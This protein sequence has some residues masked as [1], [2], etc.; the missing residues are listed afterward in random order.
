MQACIWASVCTT[1]HS[2]ASTLGP[3]LKR[4]G[5]TTAAPAYG[6]LCALESDR[7]DQY[8]TLSHSCQDSA[9]NKF[10]CA[11]L[12]AC[13]TPLNGI[14]EGSNNEY[15]VGHYAAVDTF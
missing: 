13:Q 4:A 15:T 12:H 5:L 3:L 10:L 11:C 7:A 14:N 2:A 8:A 1:V 6:G 9:A